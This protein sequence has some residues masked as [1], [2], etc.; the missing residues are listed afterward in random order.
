MF[1]L[2]MQLSGE[3]KRPLGLSRSCSKHLRAL[4]ETHLLHSWEAVCSCEPERC[5]LGCWQVIPPNSTAKFPVIFQGCKVQQYHQTV[6]SFINGC[7]IFTFQ[8]QLKTYKGSVISFT[9]SM[10][11]DAFST[12]IK[13]VVSSLAGFSGV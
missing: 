11:L 3:R 7:H 5:A 9:P 13:P 10:Y 4:C 1:L 8:V 6:E 2:V 12:M